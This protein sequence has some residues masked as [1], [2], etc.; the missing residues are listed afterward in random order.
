MARTADHGN[1]PDGILVG[2]NGTLQKR[3]LQF[4]RK[5]HTRIISNSPMKLAERGGFEPPVD[6]RPRRLSKAVL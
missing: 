5:I 3:A 6:L 1:R 4:K 2:V